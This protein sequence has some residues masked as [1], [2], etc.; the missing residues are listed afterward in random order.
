MTDIQQ[1]LISGF[2]WNKI[3]FG[4]EEW[5]FLWDVMLRTGIMF[6]MITLSLRI[7][8][9]R[10]VKQ[11]SIFELV[12]I[13]GL[14]S[15]AG[16]PMLYDDIGIIFSL[17]VFLVVIVLYSILTYFIGKFQIFEKMMEGT[18]TCL[19]KD[20]QFAINNFR[21]EKLGIQ[22]LLSELRLSGV[23]Q[24]GQ[25]ETAIEE[26]SGDIST[27][28]YPDA[29]VRYGLPIM[30]ILFEKKLRYIDKKGH[31][32]CEYCGHTEIKSAGP[33]GKCTI[34]AQELWVESSNAKRIT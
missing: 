32:S 19:I 24:L 7:L 31:Y 13:V 21:R 22:E 2:D 12:V 23:S 29:Q 26:M 28:F 9:K 20:G 4:T 10:S 25:V 34:C 1:S 5:T 14:G 3:L 18:P 17:A 27:F 30:P 8:G 11:L 16:D 15:A 6:F 33:A